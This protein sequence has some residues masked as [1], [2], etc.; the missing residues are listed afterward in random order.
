MAVQKQTKKSEGTTEKKKATSSTHYA[1]GRRKES[2]AKVYYFVS[3]HHEIEINGKQLSQ[4]FPQSMYQHLVTQP[5][6]VASREKGKWKIIVTGGGK[7]GQAEAIRLGVARV[8]V[9][10]DADLK[11]AL[12]K[13]GFLTRDPRVKERKKYGLK[14]AR[15]A[16]QWQKR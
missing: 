11:P 10:L 3:P 4:Y 8:L 7:H 1:L 13:E 16:P 9:G 12:K 6:V 2:V 5:L 15:R 14:R